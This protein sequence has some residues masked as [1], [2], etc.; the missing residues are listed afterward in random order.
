MDSKTA[1]RVRL[2][3]WRRLMIGIAVVTT[4]CGSIGL[5]FSP[6]L[7]IQDVEVVGATNVSREE[8][9]GLARLGDQSM[10]RLDLAS[11]ERRVES[12]PI[13]QDARLERRWP[14]TIRIQI[15]ERSPWALWEIGDARYVIDTEGVVLPGSA[16][17]ENAPVIRDITGVSRLAPGDQVDRDTVIAAQALLE[18]V[19]ERL[20]IEVTVL[21][22]TPQQGLA[23]LTTA[24]Y[25]VVVGDSQN[26]DYKLAVW[27][28]IEGRL[29]RETMAGHV[30]DLRF[31]D[32]PSFQ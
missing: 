14:Q 9:I 26:L 31:R 24:G 3:R 8:I 18:R 11:A 13:V 29:G 25:R 1:R 20:A 15:T 12:I 7:R 27:Q 6:V 5:Y 23:V 2:V 16:P 32:R 17:V 28:A 22:Y 4:V 19:P 10:L 30:L 21:E